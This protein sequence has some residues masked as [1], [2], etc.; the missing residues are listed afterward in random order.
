MRKVLGLIVVALVGC[1][2]GT[3]ADTRTSSPEY[4]QE[5][6]ERME[7]EWQIRKGLKDGRPTNR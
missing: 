5:M 1:G 4:K 3:T 6:R 7:K 2:G